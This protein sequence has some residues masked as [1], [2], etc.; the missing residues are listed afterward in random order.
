MIKTFLIQWQSSSSHQIRIYCFA[1]DHWMV[2]KYQ[3]TLLLDEI[4][5]G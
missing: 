2:S 1:D 5:S 3:T 4:L